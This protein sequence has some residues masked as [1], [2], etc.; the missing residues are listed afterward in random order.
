[1]NGALP[2]KII[3]YRDGVNDA[4]LMDVIEGELPALNELCMTVQ[5]G[6]E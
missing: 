5:E 4:Q 2:A 3:I 6:Y 1:M